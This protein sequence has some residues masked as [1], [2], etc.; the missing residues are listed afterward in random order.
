MAEKPFATVSEALA[1]SFTGPATRALVEQYGT[2]SIPEY[3]EKLATRILE[4]EHDIRTLKIRQNLAARILELEHDIRILKTCQNSTP[5]VNRLPPEVLSHIFLNLFWTVEREYE[6]DKKACWIFSTHVCRHWRAVALGCAA[7]WTNFMFDMHGEL[8]RT[9]LPRSKNLPLSVAMKCGGLMDIDALG[10]VLSQTTRLRHVVLSPRIHPNPPKL[11]RRRSYLDPEPD[12]RYEPPS[13][14][15]A[16]GRMGPSAPLLTTLSVSYTNHRAVERLPE[17]FL[18]EGAPALQHLQLH[19]FDLHWSRIPFSSTLKTLHL[20]PESG[21]DLYPKFPAMLETFRGLPLL[22]RLFL[23]NILPQRRFS[24]YPGLK[25]F[26]FGNQFKHLSLEDS[27]FQ[28]G[29]FL[30]GIQVP[31][32]TFINIQFIDVVEWTHG[33]DWCVKN[34]R[35]LWRDDPLDWTKE[36][37]HSL[38]L[39]Y[40]GNLNNRRPQLEFRFGGVPETLGWRYQL[41]EGDPHLTVGF[42]DHHY[43]GPDPDRTFLA[44]VHNHFD[45]TMLTTLYFDSFNKLARNP[46]FK[47]TFARLPHLRLISFGQGGMY[48]LFHILDNDP[49]CSASPDTSEPSTGGVL[50]AT[51]VP[52]FPALRVIEIY[53]ETFQKKQIDNIISVLNKRPAGHRL[54][55]LRMHDCVNLDKPEIARIEE[56]VPG[57]QVDWDEVVVRSKYFDEPSSESDSEQWYIFDG[58]GAQALKPVIPVVLESLLSTGMNTTWLFQV[59]RT[60]FSRR[61]GGAQVC[62]T[63]QNLKRDIGST[64]VL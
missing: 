32:S 3:K 14:T 7:L 45:F 56:G 58:N 61:G 6:E 15:P 38:E 36:D 8:I 53:D 47:G 30:L 21:C 44:S 37:I 54:R 64:K 23:R 51:V 41:D 1:T 62:S 17:N 2:P 25:P 12:P 50:P 16:L 11:G 9:I 20:V 24:H 28:I 35:D 49:A 52:F 10:E 22:E 13:F 55:M 42:P 29:N 31:K 34:I 26:T 40:T 46:F 39:S 59:E 33:I 60:R 5:T 18:S 57:I 4:L 48:D 63:L 19:D 43:D 27:G